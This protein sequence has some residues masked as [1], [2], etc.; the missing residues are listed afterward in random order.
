MKILY[1]SGTTQLLKIMVQKV[2]MM[3]LGLSV[4]ATKTI[5]GRPYLGHNIGK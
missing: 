3:I 1:W 4:V 2:H 5:L